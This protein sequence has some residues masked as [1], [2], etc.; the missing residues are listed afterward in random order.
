MEDKKIITHLFGSNYNYQSIDFYFGNN[1]LDLDRVRKRTIDQG[2]VRDSAA[3]CH[4]LEGM[5][6][7]AVMSI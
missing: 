6:I 5:E 2:V 3:I 1:I 4:H 7:I